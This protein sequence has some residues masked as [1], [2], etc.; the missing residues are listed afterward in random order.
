MRKFWITFFALVVLTFTGC[1]YTSTTNSTG[2]GIPD[3]VSYIEFYNGGLCIGS[4][5]DANVEIIIQTRNKFIKVSEGDGKTTFI[6]YKITVA[7]QVPTY[8]ID[9]ESLCIKYAK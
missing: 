9:S 5:N 2:T 6:T 8:I 4:Y 1:S 7:G 3:H